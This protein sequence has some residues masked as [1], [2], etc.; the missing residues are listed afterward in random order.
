MMFLGLIFLISSGVVL[1]YKVLTDIEEERKRIESISKIGMTNKE[2]QNTLLGEL[3]TIFFVPIILGGGLGLY[4][5][6]V[7]F[8][9]SSL[10]YLLVKKSIILVLIY[11]VLQVMFYFICRRRYINEVLK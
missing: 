1:Y 9:N 7:M 5:L 6:S 8:S 3:R 4:Y 11:V 2:I 10:M